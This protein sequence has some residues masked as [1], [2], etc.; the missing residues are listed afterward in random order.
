MEPNKSD[1]MSITATPAVGGPQS[2]ATVQ[3]MQYTNEMEPQYLEAIRKLIGR[4]LSEPYSIYVYRYFLFNWPDLC[5][6]ALDDNT[7]ELLGVIICK[8]EHHRSGTYRGY[9]A[10]LAVETVCR[11]RGLGS[12]LAKHAID[13]MSDKGAD[14]IVLETET[15]NTASLKLYEKLGFLCT[16]QL[17]RYYL[18]GNNAFRLALYL[19][20]LRTRAD[21]DGR[22]MVPAPSISRPWD[23]SQEYDDELYG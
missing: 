1:A 22:P 5:W 2:D 16:K 17:H 19:S 10:M 23:E 14:E 18:N 6:L 12:T 11:G 13:S 21:Q 15:N 4:D 20:D 7:K 9:I 8:L 3:Y